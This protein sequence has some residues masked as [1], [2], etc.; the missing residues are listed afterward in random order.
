M[1]S[2]IKMNISVSVEISFNCSSRAR[3]RGTQIWKTTPVA[4]K[5][6]AQNSV[7]NSE[8]LGSVTRFLPTC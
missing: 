7:K 1:D 6:R 5:V 8:K 3:R 4:S 2:T